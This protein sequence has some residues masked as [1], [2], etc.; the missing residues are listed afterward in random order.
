[1]ASE[2]PATGSFEAADLRIERVETIPVA[3]PMTTSLDVAGGGDRRPTHV[4]VKLHT[5][6]GDVGLG[7]AAPKPFFSSE[8]AASVVDAI[9]R[10]AENLV[11]GS[12]GRPKSIHRAMDDA[13]R[14][15]DFAKTAV[16]VACHDALGR[17]L[18]VPVSTLL[19]GRVRDDVPVGQSVGIKA[20]PEAV[21][22][23]ERYVHD[24]GF[25]SVKVKVGADP[26]ADEQRVRA[27]ADAVGDEV[28]IRVDANQGYTADV[29]L[30]LFRR[31]ERDLDLLLVEQ[32]V[33]R[34][35]V[36]GMRRLTRALETPVL[37]DESCFT[38]QDAYTVVNRNAADVLNIK[39][40]KAGGLVPA[41]R[42]AATA[43][44][45][46]YPVA[47][48]SMVE[49]GVGTAAGAHFAAT[50]PHAT[51]PSDVKGTTLF[52]D[53]VLVEPIDVPDGC[54]PVPTA[55]GLGVELDETKVEEY[56]VAV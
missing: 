10:M 42:I 28:P 41:S 1:M 50:L 6:S 29:A 16:D 54:T 2:L 5:A 23:A 20:T 49:L 15:N 22:E 44:A 3:V 12:A 13:I 51:Y 37:A 26:D 30:E 55:A 14:G 18:G 8:T 46:Q 34:D 40:M 48:G 56:R 9:D 47:V 7:E 24:E 33:A 52:E 36:D 38:P 27:I 11:G 43:A 25:T 35:D 39:I 21:S 19:G 17:H 45:A 4:L 53:D 32:P 31:L